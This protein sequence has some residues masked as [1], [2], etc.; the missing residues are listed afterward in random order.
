MFTPEGI[1]RATFILDLLPP[2]DAMFLFLLQLR[3]R[4]RYNNNNNCETAYRMRNV[5]VVPSRP[6]PVPATHTHTHTHTHTQT[7]SIVR[8]NRNTIISREPS[9][10]QPPFSTTRPL[11]IL[12]AA[13]ARRVQIIYPI[14]LYN[15]TIVY[16][17]W[18]EGNWSTCSNV[19]LIRIVYYNAFSR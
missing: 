10:L 2:D 13:S 7:Q 18:I 6:S 14:E 19:Y 8:Y 5:V 15:N 16:V 4:T 17:S 3:A 12:C 11:F 1:S 9:T